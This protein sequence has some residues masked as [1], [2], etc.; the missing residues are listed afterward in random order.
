MSQK[1]NFFPGLFF[2]SREHHRI[3]ALEWHAASWYHPESTLLDPFRPLRRA[4]RASR[5]AGGART[6]R[7][8]DTHRAGVGVSRDTGFRAR[9][10]EGPLWCSRSAEPLDDLALGAL[11]LGTS[12]LLSACPQRI[13][14]GSRVPTAPSPVAFLGRTRLK[15]KVVKNRG[16]LRAGTCTERLTSTRRATRHARESI[17]QRTSRES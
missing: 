8:T 6:R 1:K 17:A 15:T 7:A 16:G 2:D 11:A 9:L 13:L 5:V 4:A 3:G 12:V 14:L 10:S